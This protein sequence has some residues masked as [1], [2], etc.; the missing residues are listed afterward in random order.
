[1]ITHAALS[2][3]ILTNSI[4]SLSPLQY[5]AKTSLNLSTFPLPECCQPPPPLAFPES[6][7]LELNLEASGSASL[8]PSAESLKRR[9]IFLEC[10]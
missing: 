2:P 6:V 1:M 10:L 8:A 7:Y 3:S 5:N 4:T 9:S